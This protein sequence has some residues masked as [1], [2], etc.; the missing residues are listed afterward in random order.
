MGWDDDKKGLPFLR[1]TGG[2]TIAV[3]DKML[4]ANYHPEGKTY[5]SLKKENVW[6]YVW[7]KFIDH[8]SEGKTIES[9]FE[10]L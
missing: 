10:T 8:L 9:F 2:S 7:H 4:A 6:L 5:H 1:Q 3:R